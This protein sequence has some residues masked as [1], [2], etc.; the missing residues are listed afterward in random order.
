MMKVRALNSFV[1]Y[2]R[3]GKK[4]RVEAGQEFELPA[5][6]DWLDKGLVE[7][8]EAEAK[9]T[10]KARKIKGTQEELL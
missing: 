2:D 4:H 3:T 7:A 5:G 10:A 1:G 6:V 9:A 8:V